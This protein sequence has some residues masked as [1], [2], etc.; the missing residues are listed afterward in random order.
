MKRKRA[1]SVCALALLVVTTCACGGDDDSSTT[2]QASPDQ[3]ACS[4]FCTNFPT[5]CPEFAAK[6]KYTTAEA[7]TKQCVDV[8]D[9]S[10]AF[11]QCN[12]EAKSCD[13]LAAC[14][15]KF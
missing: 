11:R 3:V 14:K 13:D 2:T 15:N 10:T 5:V 1:W 4:T 12:A 9:S 8:T 7:C 6:D